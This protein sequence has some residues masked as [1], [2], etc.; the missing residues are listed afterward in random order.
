M[1][2]ARYSRILFGI[3]TI[4]LLLILG[5]GCSGS[6]YV[7]GQ[8]NLTAVYEKRDIK[9]TSQG[10]PLLEFTAWY[11]GDTMPNF[12]SE[13]DDVLSKFIKEKFNIRVKNIQSKQGLTYKD[14]LSLY[15]ASNTLPDVVF[16]INDK[17][18]LASTGKFA[19]LGGIIKDNCPN[20]LSI[21]PESEWGDCLYN[22]KMYF[23]PRITK[24]T[25]AD[26]LK[27]DIYACPIKNWAGIWTKESILKKLGYEFTP[28]EKINQ[29]VNDTQTK[30]TPDDLKITPQIATTEDFYNF[31]KK[32][33]TAIKNQDGGEIIPFSMPIWLEPHFG[34]TFGLTANWKYDPVEKSVSQ[35]LGDKHAREYWQFINKLYREGLLDKEFALQKDD[36]LQEKFEL[37]RVACTL[38]LK[39][40]DKANESIKKIDPSDN[41]RMIPLPLKRGTNFV[42]IDGASK[43]TFEFYINKDF[44]DIPRLLK[45]FDWSLTDEYMDLKVWGPEELGLWEIKDGKKVWKD[46]E[47]YKALSNNDLNVMKEKYFKYGLGGKSKVEY[48]LPGLT[49][50]MDTW[51]RSYPFH[52]NKN[53]PYY[54]SLFISSAGLDWNGYIRSGINELTSLAP[55]FIYGEF[56]QQYSPLL[57]AARSDEEFNKNW[58]EVF[59]IFINKVKYY[60][61]KKQMEKAYRE[62]GL[63]VID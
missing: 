4:S 42:G 59:N 18:T 22:G 24:N 57:F 54:T 60:E 36:Q 47:L 46:E 50:D 40:H 5:T 53:D 13:N 44:K 61:A 58:N 7:T 48:A 16:N 28:I 15:I 45:L 38:D 10:L 51:K 39:D 26:E 34:A 2:I 21:F 35:F 63:V 6:D 52:V 41:L 3:Y 62:S 19:E 1:K 11:W 14:K 20:L 12:V 9:D 30:P 29:K 31:L 33:K 55:N 8:N 27:D 23:F 49:V 37:G 32:I 43:S 17:I 25:D 56:Q